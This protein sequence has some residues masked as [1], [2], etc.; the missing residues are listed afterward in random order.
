MNPSPSTNAVAPTKAFPLRVI[1]TVTT[2]RLLTQGKGPRDNGISDLYEILGWMTDDSPFTHQLGRFA[3]ECKP[4]LLKWFPEL[5]LASAGLK[6]LDKWLKSD[7]TG[8]GEGIEMWLAELRMLHP[9]IQLS[10]DVPKIPRETHCVHDPMA[11]L[12]AMRGAK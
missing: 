4:H 7:R 12:I 8:G 3:D 6:N 2:G 9:S 1:L 11:E 5:A 10:Y